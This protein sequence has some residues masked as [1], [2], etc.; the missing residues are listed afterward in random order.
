MQTRLRDNLEEQHYGHGTGVPQGSMELLYIW[1]NEDETGFIQQQGFN[2]SPNYHFEMKVIGHNDNGEPM[3]ELSCT[4]N[5]DYPNVWKTGNIVNLT[6]VVGE[7]GS[8]KSSLLRC[9][10]NAVLK[11]IN[12]KGKKQ[13]RGTEMVQV[14]RCNDSIKALHNMGRD[15]LSNT[16]Y[17]HIFCVCSAEKLL[18]YQTRIYMTNAFSASHLDEK[19]DWIQKPVVFSPVVNNV[20]SKAFFHKITGRNMDSDLPNAFGGIQ[21]EMCR[22]LGFMEFEQFARISYY[23]HLHNEM[24]LHSSLVID[25]KDIIVGIRNPSDFFTMEGY[26]TPYLTNLD[27]PNSALLYDPIQMYKELRY[28]YVDQLFPNP[29]EALVASITYEVFKLTEHLYPEHATYE[30]WLTNPYWYIDRFVR[31][32]KNNPNYHRC[33]L[34]YYKSAL[35]EI[36]ELKEILTGCPSVSE[37]SVNI[38]QNAIRGVLVE[39]GS[40]AYHRF[41]QFV[42]KMMRQ[43]Y[44]FV[45][46]YLNIEMTP[47]SSGEQALHNI[48]SWLRL[49]PSFKEILGEESVPIQDNVLLLLDEVDLYMH[50]EWQRK[51][52]KYLSDELALEYPNKHVQIIISTHSPLVLSDIPSG[53]I[54]YLE[55]NDEKCTIAQRSERKESFGANIFSLLKDSFFLKRS[56]GEFAYSK[57]SEVIE[58][59]E[60]LKKNRGDQELQ[61]KCKAHRPFIDIIGEPVLR[62]KLQMMHDDI[63]GSDDKNPDELA[64]ERVEQ[65]LKRDSA[66]YRERLLKMLSDAESE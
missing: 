46:K 65:L 30:Q 11:P 3:Y 4:E 9:L 63:L 2:F 6:A 52:L 64:L 51:F 18:D 37:R 54:I 27:N 39:H 28:H 25:S 22:Y 13:H 58:D 45:L 10:V 21:S 57:I 8:G 33:V 14:Y 47:L 1:I 26:E 40:Y 49:P 50:P 20:R 36:E 60:K 7:N 61:E 48:F 23:H 41:C 35:D 59:L 34:E 38:D 31:D 66:K 24:R 19:S 43:R 15:K 12:R 56:L 42:D 29:Y 32:Y 17:D 16:G 44:S 5:P 62:R 55:K 53:N